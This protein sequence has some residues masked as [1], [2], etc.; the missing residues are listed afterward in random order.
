MLQLYRGVG[1]TWR[2]VIHNES[3]LRDCVDGGNAVVGAFLHARTF[4][5]LYFFSRP[6]R[7]RWVLM[8]SQS[9]DGDAI[10]YVEQRL[11]FRL[12]RGSSGRGGARALVAL[13]KQQRNDPALSAGLSID[14]SRGPRGIAQTGG[15][16]LAQKTGGLVLPI[17]AS[18]RQAW[19]YGRSWDRLV[20]PRPFAAI[21]V[22]VG[23]PIRVPKDA[24][25]VTLETLRLQLE[26][27]VLNL[28]GEL[29]TLT[30]FRD[31]EPLRAEG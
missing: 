21:H 10:A 31:S 2:Y 6:N 27:A 23:A 17:A 15:L 30:G 14:G 8:C 24:D 25:A 9:R 7:G 20:L 13:I 16:V 3:R 12:V 26:R 1:A 5:L 18:T 22:N 4:P 28:N 19:V 29:D 11:G